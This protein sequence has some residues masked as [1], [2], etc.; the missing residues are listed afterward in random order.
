MSKIAVLVAEN[1][2]P[3]AL[4]MTLKRETGLGVS[5]IRQCIQ[6]GTVIYQPEL[7]MND[8]VEIAER[9][10]RIL[11]AAEEHEVG[12]TL[13]ELQP[14]EELESAPLDLCLISTENLRNIL[15]QAEDEFS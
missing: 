15:L 13:Y 10:R 12:L 6:Q 4:L 3:N 8:H 5:D 7:F 14:D 2:V 1:Q 9:L 11:L